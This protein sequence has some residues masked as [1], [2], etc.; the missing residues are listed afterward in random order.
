[1]RGIRSPPLVKMYE[2]TTLPPTDGQPDVG[3]LL[4]GGKRHGS[5][6]PAPPPESSFRKNLP[7]VGPF[8]GDELKVLNANKL[9]PITQSDQA[10]IR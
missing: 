1:M 4:R 9:I 3:A 8:C 2:T 10:R 7:T 5:G 6:D